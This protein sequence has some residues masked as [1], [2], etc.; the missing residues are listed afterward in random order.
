VPTLIVGRINGR[1]G[2]LGSVPIQ[3]LDCSLVRL[4]ELNPV[5]R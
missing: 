2:T 4:Y 3:H 1:F 5:D